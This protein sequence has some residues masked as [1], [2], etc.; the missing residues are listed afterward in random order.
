M[1]MI[2]PIVFEDL[3]PLP[4]PNRRETAPLPGPRKRTINNFMRM[5]H[6]I[7]AAWNPRMKTAITM[8]QTFRLPEL[9]LCKKKT[10]SFSR[11]LLLIHRRR[12]P[13]NSKA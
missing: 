4:E 8:P 11:L 2:E 6:R 9:V 12:H 5:R 1:T 7:S 10:R 3:P 13:S